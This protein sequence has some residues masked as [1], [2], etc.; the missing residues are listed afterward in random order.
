MT[1]EQ[2]N[3][4][5]ARLLRI[6]TETYGVD[7]KLME[8]AR[9]GP[10]VHMLKSDVVGDVG[11]LLWVLMGTVGVVLLIACANITNLL[12]VGVEGR[13]QELAIRAALGAG[14]LRIARELLVGSLLLGLLGG[15][16]GLGIAHGGLRLLVTLAPANLPRAAEMSLDPVVLA[17]TLA[18]SL[19]SGLLFGLIPVLKYARSPLAAPLR[20]GRGGTR[21]RERQLSQNALVV[22][23]IALALVV[24]VGSGLMLRS[25]QE[26]LSVDP[27]S[28]PRRSCSSRALQYR[29]RRPQRLT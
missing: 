25:F 20:G 17:F 29:P 16:L 9:I 14:R 18:V 15:A 26:L 8:N 6:W 5:V 28:P 1:L 24:L 4:D 22:T 10:D 12:L 2:A 3:A 7:R 21:S 13:R 19:F 23:Q 27:G 11:N